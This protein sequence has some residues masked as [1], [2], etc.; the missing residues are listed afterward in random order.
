MTKEQK[1][2]ADELQKKMHQIN[3]QLGNLTYIETTTAKPDQPA[4]ISTYYG[5]T[6]RC[7]TIPES[8]RPVV[9]TLLRAEIQK[10]LDTLESEFAAL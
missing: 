10:G 6:H 9:L 8:L 7:V 3:E 2:K 4:V 1:G 5:D